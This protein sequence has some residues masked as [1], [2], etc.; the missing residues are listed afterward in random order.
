MTSRSS[1]HFS[2]GE[3]WQKYLDEMP[4]TAIERMTAYVTDW[5]GS[6]LRGLRL[7]DIGSGQGLTSLAAHRA[8]ADVVSMDIDPASVEA[9][10]R[11]WAAA[12]RPRNWT[13][14]QG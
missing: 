2:F 10:R 8:G 12:E 6:D 14:T 4:A 7:I 3:N 5:L 13:I 11:L 1:R 9:T